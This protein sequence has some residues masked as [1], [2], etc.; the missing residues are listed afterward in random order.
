MSEHRKSLLGHRFSGLTCSALQRQGFSLGGKNTVQ[1]N[2]LTSLHSSSASLHS[3]PASLHSQLLTSSS[4]QA[5]LPFQA[6]RRITPELMRPFDPEV[7]RAKADAENTLASI[8]NQGCASFESFRAK[9]RA[10]RSSGIPGQLLDSPTFHLV[11]GVL[12][13]ACKKMATQSRGCKPAPHAIPLKAKDFCDVGNYLGTDEVSNGCWPA[14]GT[15]KIHLSH[16]YHS[17]E[18]LE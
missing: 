17:N 18:K 14:Y 12:Y 9:D 10:L 5:Q 6:L 11:P 1:P 2:P 7:A 3:S 15:V 8:M 16:A 4:S 13:H